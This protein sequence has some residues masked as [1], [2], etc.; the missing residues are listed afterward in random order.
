[1]GG[2]SSNSEHTEK[3]DLQQQKDKITFSELAELH[4]LCFHFPH[5]Y[6]KAKYSFQQGLTIGVTINHNTSMNITV[7]ERQREG[8]NAQSYCAFDKVHHGFEV[9]VKKYSIVQDLEANHYTYT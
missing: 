4:F 7:L 3:P 6:K 5:M 2:D 8:N 1:M 9:S